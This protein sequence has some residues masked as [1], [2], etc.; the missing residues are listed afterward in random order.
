MDWIEDLKEVVLINSYT[1]NKRG[2]DEVGR[3]FRR[4]FEEIDF[5]CQVY[6]R[7]LIGDHL[8]FK[9]KRASKQRVLLLGHLDTVFPKGEFEGFREDKDWV[10]GAG[11]CDMK[12]GNVV[13]IEALRSLYDDLG[14]I[15]DIDMLL[16]SDEET[17]SDDSRSLTQE[18]AKDYDICFVFEAS[19]KNLEVATW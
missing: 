13:A 5:E 11:V 4:W 18:L 6:A 3:V 15:F 9:S 17:G 10:Y 14:E 19:G 12:G 16:V 8:L 2:V 7:E 1:L